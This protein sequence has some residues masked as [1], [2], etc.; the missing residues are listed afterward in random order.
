MISILHFT[1]TSPLPSVFAFCLVKHGCMDL[2]M[3]E[4]FRYKK[5]KYS[6]ISQIKSLESL[7]FRFQILLQDDFKKTF[8]FSR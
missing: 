6:D 1:C 2:V 4:N 7:I 5:K 8:S 3:G